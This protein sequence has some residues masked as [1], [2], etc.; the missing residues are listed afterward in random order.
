MMAHK[1][2]AIHKVGKDISKLA[3]PP[4]MSKAGK[5]KLIG[6]HKKM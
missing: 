3:K 6:Y 1:K 4:K 2:K 5:K